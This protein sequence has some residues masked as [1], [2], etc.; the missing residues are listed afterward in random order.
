M[1][2]AI[3][4]TLFAL[5]WLLGFL[6]LAISVHAVIRGRDYIALSNEDWSR[7]DLKSAF[8]SNWIGLLVFRLTIP[9]VMIVSGWA[10]YT[11]VHDLAWPLGSLGLLDRDHG[12]WATYRYVLASGFGAPLGL[13]FGWWFVRLCRSA[14]AGD[15]HFHE[16]S[17][18][19]LLQKTVAK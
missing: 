9:S 3:T 17:T 8:Q 7:S 19:D 10:G 11:L 2:N 18:H 16:L 14:S 1:E 12:E 13:F 5:F 6:V 15:P 4:T